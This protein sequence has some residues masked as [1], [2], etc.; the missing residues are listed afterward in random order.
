V[1]KTKWD[2]IVAGAGAVGSAALYQLARR[3]IK[4]LGIDRWRPPH[5]N[6]SSHGD[7]R[8]TRLAL[9]EGE[10]YVQFA[11]RSH[12]IW[13]ELEAATG[14]TLLRQVGGLVFGPQSGRT[15]AHG[16]SDFLGTTI[17]VAKKAGLS[18]EILDAAA[19]WDRFPQFRWRGDETGCLEHGAG[20]VHPEA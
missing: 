1:I 5:A 4:A 9:G 15:R 12:G 2:V 17:A 8:I 10:E 14:R 11:S 3:G 7:T 6:G 13:R 18:H 16:A 20:F 19:L